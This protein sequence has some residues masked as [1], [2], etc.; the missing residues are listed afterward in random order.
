[1]RVIPERLPLR[2]REHLASRAFRFVF[3]VGIA[4]LFADFTYEAARSINGQFLG[5]LGAAASVVGFTAGLGELLGYG[6]RSVTGVLA[7]R[8][9][10]YW[11][12]AVLGYVVNMA[13]VPALA[14]AGDWPLAA[15]LIITE[16]TGRAIRKPSTEAMLSHAGS[17]LGQGWVFG[18]NEALDQVGAMLGP[19]VIAGVL[20]LRGTY[21]TGYALLSVTAV[22]TVA[23]V[24]V[25]RRS[26]RNPYELEAGRRLDTHGLPRTFWGYLLASSCVA[27]G[28]ADFALIAYHLQHAAVVSRDMIPVLYSVA[29]GVGA[30]GAIVLG[31]LLDRYHIKLVVGVFLVS[32]FFAPLVFLGSAW[33]VLGGMVLWGVS[34]SA[35]DS[36]LK[37]LVAGIASSARRATA[38]GV[39]DTGFGVAWFAGSWLMGYLYGRSVHAVVVF[40]LAVQL[41]ALPLFALTA[42]RE[43]PLLP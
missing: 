33:V 28:F 14:L 1:M 17:Q 11:L 6:L 13:A 41:L 20:L 25:A 29:M 22:L 16:R 26:F 24:L 36:V 38:F 2:L 27:A 21:R 3:V 10:R 34:M 31:R 23:T 5:R 30:L 42:R 19:L 32:A 40:S 8:T 7:D 12:G 18:L 35:Q 9:G 43:R 37:S 15:G 39:F 4:N